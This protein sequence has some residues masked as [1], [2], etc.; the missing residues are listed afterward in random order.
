[1]HVHGISNQYAMMLP[2]QATQQVQAERKA[3]AE[4][5][6]KLTTFGASAVEDEVA[7][8]D[9]YAD[10]ERQREQEQPPDEEAFREVLI[11]FKA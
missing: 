5:R 9:A 6:R 8:T 4:V 3:A 1:M 11:S 10:D 2:S 7:R